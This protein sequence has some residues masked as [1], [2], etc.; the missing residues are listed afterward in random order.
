[1]KFSLSRK[2]NTVLATTAS[3][4]S[5]GGA[6]QLSPSSSSGV[7]CRSPS[8]PRRRRSSKQPTATGLQAD[9]GAPPSDLRLVSPLNSGGFGSELWLRADPLGAKA[10]RRPVKVV[11][12]RLFIL[13]NTTHRPATFQRIR[14]VAIARESWPSSI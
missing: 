1:M 11:L 8:I 4:L 5:R 10:S 12:T 9:L 7:D 2:A 13:N 3:L 6:P 14:I